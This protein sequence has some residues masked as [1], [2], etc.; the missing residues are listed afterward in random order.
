MPS[1]EILLLLLLAFIAA[2]VGSGN[3]LGVGHT[4]DDEETATAAAEDR[5]KML[6]TSLAPKDVVVVVVGFA[7]WML[8]RSPNRRMTSEVV[9]KMEMRMSMMMI[10]V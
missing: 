10:Q 4:Q 5:P 6:A 8:E 7:V 2:V 1:I 3:I 9:T